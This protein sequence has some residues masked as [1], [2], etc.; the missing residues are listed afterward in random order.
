M[1]KAKRANRDLPGSDILSLK[2]PIPRQLVFF[3]KVEATVNFRFGLANS[4]TN[5]RQKRKLVLRRRRQAGLSTN[6]QMKYAQ[7]IPGQVS[8]TLAKNEPQPMQ[9][10]RPQSQAMEISRG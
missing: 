4:V 6:R 2:S 10:L 8:R 9:V 3:A 5:R 1:P 7:R